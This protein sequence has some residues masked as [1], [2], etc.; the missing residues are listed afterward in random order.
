VTLLALNILTGLGTLRPK[1]T[2]IVTMETF[3]KTPE[4]NFQKTPK[5]TPNI[6]VTVVDVILQ[7]L[8]YGNIRNRVA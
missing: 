4:K 8:V 1:N 6:F 7:N 3:W 2:F 5:K